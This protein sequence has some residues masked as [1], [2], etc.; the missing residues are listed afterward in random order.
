MAMIKCSECNKDISN[1]AEACINCGAPIEDANSKDKRK[2]YDAK[3]GKERKP[4]KWELERD[5]AVNISGSHKA[6]GFTYGKHLF[7]ICV[8]LIIFTMCQVSS[9]NSEKESELLKTER[10]RVSQVKKQEQEQRVQKIREERLEQEKADKIKGFHCLS[11]W[12]GSLAELKREVKNR[13]RNPKSF[14]HVETKVTPANK[15]GKHTAIMTY[16]AENGFGGMTVGVARA[17]YNNSDCKYV[18]LS[19]E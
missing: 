3:T 7:W 10:E 5:G 13:T 14:K 19:Y 18:V 2:Y 11:A 17:L 15:Q 4:Y 1:K 12:D 6:G 16:R 9:S 8:S